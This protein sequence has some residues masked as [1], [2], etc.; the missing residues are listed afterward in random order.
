M[1]NKRAHAAGPEF[2]HTLCDTLS[3]KEVATRYVRKSGHAKSMDVE[4]GV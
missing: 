2:K 3:E 4:V 1:P